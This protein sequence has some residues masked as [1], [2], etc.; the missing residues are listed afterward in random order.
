MATVSPQYFD[1]SVCAVKPM[2]DGD[3]VAVKHIPVSAAEGNLLSAE[4]DGLA[5]TADD[6]ISSEEG[7]LLKKSNADGGALLKAGD[8]IADEAC[9]ILSVTNDGKVTFHVG[10]LISTVEGG[11]VLGVN[12]D[13]CKLFINPCLLPGPQNIVSKDE[14]NLIVKDAEDCSALLRF[15]DAVSEDAG[16]LIQPGT[17]GKLNVN[18]QYMVD[19]GYFGAGL[20]YVE[21]Q[22]GSHVLQVAACDGLKFEEGSVTDTYGNSYTAKWLQVNLDESQNV[23]IFKE[24]EGCVEC[25]TDCKQLSIEFSLNA[26]G[27]RLRILDSTGAVFTDCALSNG[28][29]GDGNGGLTINTLDAISTT[30][31]TNDLPV[32]SKAVKAAI[33]ALR[34]ELIPHAHETTKFGAGTATLYG[35]VKLSDATNSTSGTGDGVAASPSAVNTLRVDLQNQIDNLPDGG[36]T[37]LLVKNFSVLTQ[38]SNNNVYYYVKGLVYTPNLANTR[39]QIETYKTTKTSATA[40]IYKAAFEVEAQ[41]V[42]ANAAV[43]SSVTYDSGDIDNPASPTTGPLCVNMWAYT[44]QSLAQRIADEL[45][46]RAPVPLSEIANIYIANIRMEQASGNTGNSYFFYCVDGAGP[47]APS[48]ADGIGGTT[49]RI[50]PKKAWML[51]PNKSYSV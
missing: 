33:D 11:N 35:H 23:L 29:Q 4:P 17:D 50:I 19:R 5:V 40:N 18:M 42:A 48:A 44:Y 20:V 9:N 24:R 12:P 16:N 10:D 25:F 41:N 39:F 49:S 21:K 34:D 14:G 36:Y 15:R 51:G 13:D 8:I 7:N 46:A 30:A 3:K 38:R 26:S 47:G 31:P 45:N 27:E 32:S 28:L 2:A 22:D 6:F 43:P 37:D 1:S